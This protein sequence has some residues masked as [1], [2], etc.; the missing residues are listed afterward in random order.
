MARPMSLRGLFQSLAYITFHRDEI[1]F[2]DVFR[3]TTI[4]GPPLMAISSAL[5]RRVIGVFGDAR[6]AH[7]RESSIVIVPSMAPIRAF[8]TTSLRS[9][10]SSTA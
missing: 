3:G 1:A 6:M 8:P 9:R 5:P 7:S 10:W 4:S 2:L